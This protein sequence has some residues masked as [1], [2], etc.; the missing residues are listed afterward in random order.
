[1]TDKMFVVFT[2]TRDRREIDGRYETDTLQGALQRVL[3]IAGD[4]ELKVAK[5][6]AVDYRMMSMKE[7]VLSLNGFELKLVDKEVPGPPSP[8]SPS[9]PFE[10]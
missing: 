8:P 3:D 9:L 1:M 7:M 5:V 2:K 4:P 6:I 10:F